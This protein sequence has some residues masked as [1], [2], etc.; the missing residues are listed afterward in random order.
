ML[1]ELHDFL[2]P[3]ALLPKTF[4]KC[5]LIPLNHA[6]VIKSFPS[7]T[8]TAEITHGVGQVLLKMLEIRRFGD[9]QKNR[10]RGKKIP[11]GEWYSKQ[12]EEVED[13]ISK[14]EDEEEEVGNK[15]VEADEDE[16][17]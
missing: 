2:N 8:K 7:T 13:D 4:E 5:G 9:G 1:K 3:A 10:P 6:K 17:E 12:D 14:Q 11:T 16:V 15:E